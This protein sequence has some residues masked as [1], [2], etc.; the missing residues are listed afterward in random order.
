MRKGKGK[1]LKETPEQLLVNQLIADGSEVN[2]QQIRR[3][4]APTQAG[5]VQ[6]H[7]RAYLSKLCHNL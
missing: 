1:G 6:M 4:K 5:T 7:A 3:V 2:P